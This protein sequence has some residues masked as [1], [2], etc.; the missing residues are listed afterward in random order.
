MTTPIRIAYVAHPVGADGPN[1]ADNLA[2]VQRWLRWLIVNHEAVAFSV[3]WL[4]Y[5]MVL[6]EEHRQRGMRDNFAA[7]ARCDFICLVGGQMS[8]GMQAERDEAIRLGLPI[9]DYLHHGAEP[10]EFR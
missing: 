9:V 7:L 8:P 10:P 4:P 6:S 5:C 2:R 1:R 3:P